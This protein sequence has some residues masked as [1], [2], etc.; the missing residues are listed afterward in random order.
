MRTLPEPIE[1]L[2]L[3][4]DDAFDPRAVL[5]LLRERKWAILS[6]ASVITVLVV[7]W[8]LRQP[9]IYEAVCTIQ[10]DP[11]PARALGS[12]V[13]DVAAPTINFWMT[14]EWYD[15][16]NEIIAS[17]T[18]AERVV[19]D[20]ALNE[21]PDFF[22][23]PDKE[24]ADWEAPSVSEAALVLIERLTVKQAQDTRI[25]EIKIRDRDPERATLLANGVAQA[26]IEHTRQ[27]RAS[28][29]DQA[30]TFL[31]ARLDQLTTELRGS[32][33]A[34]HQFR[35][36][37]NVLSV[38]L[39]DRQN[40]IARDLERYSAAL[41]AANTRRIEVAA[42]LQALRAA[43]NDD[44]M[45]VDAALIS[46]NP[47][48]IALRTAYRE[49]AADLAAESLRYGENHP[50]VREL[51]TR[52]EA[53]REQ[54]RQEI[55]SIISGVASELREMRTNVA[56][57]RQALGEVHAAGLALNQREIRYNELKRRR[58][59]T[60]KLYDMVLERTT[61]TD[62]TKM[63][64]VSTVRMVDTALVPEHPVSPRMVLNLA[65]GLVMG[66]IF[67]L[68]MAL[69]SA[70]MD[71]TL[72]T[73]ADAERLGI[74]V[75]G[76]LPMIAGAK[77]QLT[78]RRFGRHR[79]KRLAPPAGIPSRDLVVHNEPMSSAAESAR[80]IRT[81]LTFMAAK[82]PLRSLLL[83]SPS[84]LEG[85]TTVAISVAT[86]LAQGGKSVVLV[87]TD[88]RRPRLH[89]AF[90][91]RSSIGVTSV[92]V[93]QK[94][95]EAALQTTR[96]PNLSLLPCGPIPPNPSELLHTPAFAALVSSLKERFDH[97]IFDSPPIGAVTDSA[98]VA[99][100]VDGVILVLKS[101]QTTRDAATSALKQLRAVGA[102]VL[103]C[104]LNDVDVAKQEAYYGGQYYYS[105]YYYGTNPEQGPEDG[106]S[107]S[108]EAAE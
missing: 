61:E 93:A 59:N 92:L 38:A 19:R 6:T 57:L 27:E 85:K 15:T 88:M 76:L 56:G 54:L 12:D 104:V 37:N 90:E 105:G 42:K 24:R 73:V 101:E 71:R 87:D 29:T 99:P 11:A 47:S 14:Q 100:Q 81:N 91:L 50:S 20:L 60:E 72:K 52:L 63:Q 55:N 51:N 77:G 86:A 21:N 67:G 96:V 53:I 39:E 2:P 25:V 74:T 83:T 13:E 1:P 97:V 35:E 3:D 49:A 41:T 80:A 36:D 106:A 26:Y 107:D 22:Y 43:N 30:V 79:R 69:L 75:L 103:G 7:F 16:Q 68:G 82:E 98:I 18:V 23:V 84:P 5:R 58:T 94:T 95:L 64:K 102:N 46:Q 28:A 89:R 33:E 31:A 44:P 32:E 17:R 9:K 78:P 48:V 8:T 4:A 62:L 65:G 66:L 45:Q 108:A 10:Y 40:V 70:R 34:L